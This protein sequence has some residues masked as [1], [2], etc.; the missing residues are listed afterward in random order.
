MCVRNFTDS[1]RL[2]SVYIGHPIYLTSFM[3]LTMVVVCI[4]VVLLNN[5]V[6]LKLKVND[7]LIIFLYENVVSCFIK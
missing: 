1:A 3:P 5:F 6:G 4:S 7:F 2:H